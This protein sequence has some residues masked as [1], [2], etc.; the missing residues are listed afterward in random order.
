[1]LAKLKEKT[2]PQLWVS[3]GRQPV[4]RNQ[5]YNVDLLL[6]RH[7]QRRISKSLI[8]GM[9]RVLKHQDLQMLGLKLNKY[10]EFS[11]T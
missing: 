2:W 6:A 1:M 11:P 5:S 10:E 7:L 9:K 3:K 4:N 8:L